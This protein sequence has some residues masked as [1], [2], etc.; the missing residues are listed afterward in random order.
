MFFHFIGRRRLLLF[1]GVLLTEETP[2]ELVF[3]YGYDVALW[4]ENI[5]GQK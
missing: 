4:L 3:M 5:E 2:K 1:N